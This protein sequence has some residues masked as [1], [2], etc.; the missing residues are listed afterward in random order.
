MKL[1][2]FIAASALFCCAL[3]AVACGPGPFILPDDCDLY[4]ILP[5]YAELREP[6]YGRVEANCRAWKEAVG[7][8]S[9]AA[10][11][12]A[13]YGFSLADWQRVQ[14]GDDR[15]NAFCRRLIETH[16]TDA[17]R[18]L[19]WSKYY[20]QWSNQMRSPWYYG[21]GMDD[22]G[23]DIDSIAKVAVTYNG[24]YADRYL[25][26][27]VKCLFR[28]GRDEDCVALWKKHK[29]KMQGS[30][31][32]DMAEGYVAICYT[33][34][35]R[36]N[37]AF[38]IYVRQGDAASL[39]MFCDDNVKVFEQVMRHHPN[40]PFFPIALQRVLFVV[41]NYPVDS[42]FTSYI[43]DDSQLRRLLALATR[44]GK[45]PRVENQALWRYTAACLLDHMGRRREALERLDGVSAKDEF[46]DASIRLLRIHLHSRLDG[47]DDRYEQQLFT[48]LQ[49]I[50][51]RMQREWATLDSA[52]RYRLSH[53]D[54][55]GYNWDV[56]RTVYSYDALR[57]IVLGSGGLA[58][59]FARAGRTTRAIQLANM[60][61]NRFF[62]ISRNPVIEHYRTGSR[63]DSL[64]LCWNEYNDLK[65]YNGYGFY[66]V[67]IGTSHM[68][69]NC[70]AEGF[71]NPHDYSNRLFVHID[72]MGA[73]VLADYWKNVEEG[74]G[75]MD[76][77]LNERG[78][79]GTNYW[80]DIIG[81]HLLREMRYA[82]AAR[83][84]WR[85]TPGFQQ[86]LNTMSWM[87]VDPFSYL[88][89]Q[90]KRNW[91]YKACYAYRMARLERQ[92]SEAASPDD[93]AD[94][95]LSLSIALRNAFS[96]RCWPLVSYGYS[97]YEGFED[98]SDDYPTHNYYWY[99]YQSPY[100]DP[101]YLASDM[102][103]SAVAPYA[104]KAEK[105]AAELRKKA[106]ATYQD[107]DRIAQAYRR[108][109]QFT[110]LMHHYADTPAGQFV[111]RH[112]DYWKDYLVK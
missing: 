51:A 94:A 54:G 41:E 83:W 78:Y 17:V 10:V 95:M 61:E 8:V 22:G 34:M 38:D 11:R 30:H 60:A 89:T 14:R 98:D 59:R 5:Y 73:D 99:N 100:E 15:G 66:T 72:R 74:R 47:I 65:N 13:V 84:L 42:R 96:E 32:H 68:T 87:K 49:W 25:F 80:Y 101:Y 86:R 108:T 109:C 104:A 2:R 31:L 105:R 92:A 102:A 50:D 70:Y 26:L 16:D 18:L 69:D 9:E 3:R 40:S 88:G 19:V 79:T 52:D 81:T 93:R 33:R 6:D 63:R 12:Q 28:S 45:D 62:Q 37:E 48:D 7:G 27:A 43:F 4:R 55:F 107:R 82:E 111:A 110:Y 67:D 20:E 29:G 106:F 112:C 85:V 90:L 77:W 35:G 56:Y 58:D 39:Q 71:F 23:L 57:R 91:N 53:F 64:Y 1:K 75:Q 103:S 97:S 46:L 21:C 36:D 76:T 24:R 44:A